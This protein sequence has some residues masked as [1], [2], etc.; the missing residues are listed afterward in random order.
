MAIRLS[1]EGGE[2][3]HSRTMANNKPIVERG[4]FTVSA[5]QTHLSVQMI[6][7]LKLW[8]S[9]FGIFKNFTSFSE[10]E[11]IVNLD[12]EGKKNSGFTHTDLFFYVSMF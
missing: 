5:R 6:L 7:M 11:N 4:K 12:S 2:G 3:L 10:G 1:K 8:S 9:C